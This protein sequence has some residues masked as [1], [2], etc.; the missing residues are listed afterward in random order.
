MQQKK[1]VEIAMQWYIDGLAVEL[2]RHTDVTI[3]EIYKRAFD[4]IRPTMDGM[5]DAS[6]RM[7]FTVPDKPSDGQF[8]PQS[9]FMMLV[10]LTIGLATYKLFN[11]RESDKS[12]DHVSD[13]VAVFNLL[14]ELGLD[15]HIGPSSG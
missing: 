1:D 9:A 7:G 15:G 13:R 2:A 5:A 4:N 10:S 14:A 12:A 3:Q 11:Y 8:N 6:T